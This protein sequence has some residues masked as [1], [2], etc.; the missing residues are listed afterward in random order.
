MKQRGFKLL[1]LPGEPETSA[2]PELLHGDQSRPTVLPHLPTFLPPPVD[3]GS[4]KGEA[5]SE[6]T[7]MVEDVSAEKSDHATAEEEPGSGGDTVQE[8]QQSRVR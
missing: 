6:R 8:K 2:P 5:K 1:R 4:H 3:S 7:E